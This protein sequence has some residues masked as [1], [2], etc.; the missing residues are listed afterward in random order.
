MG[1]PKQGEQD[2]SER[3][4]REQI[5][6]GVNCASFT[7]EC[8][9]AQLGF[10]KKHNTGGVFRMLQITRPR[11]RDLC[12]R[13]RKQREKMFA[14]AEGASGENVEYSVQ[15]IRKSAFYAARFGKRYTKQAV[16]PACSRVASSRARGFCARL[17]KQRGKDVR[18]R[19][20]R[21]R[22]EFG[23]HSV[24]ALRTSALL[25]TRVSKKCTKQAVFFECSGV[26][27]SRTRGFCAPPKHRGKDARERRMRARRKFGSFYARFTQN[28]L[29]RQKVHKTSGISRMLQSR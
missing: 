9:L 29:S 13:H 1:L 27:C 3:R 26:T 10:G 7:Q 5:K 14:S 15:A 28:A 16:F 2:V 25:A 11:A 4:R 12:K 23:A 21:E 17:Q 8:F 18:E 6:F 22:S 19:R 24:R 20:R